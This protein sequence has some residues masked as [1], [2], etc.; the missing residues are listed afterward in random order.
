MEIEFT[1]K[2]IVYAYVTLGKSTYD[3]AKILKTYPNKVARVLEKA[4]IPLRTRAEAQKQALKSGRHEHPTRGRKRTE[5][6]KIKISES[7]AKNWENLSSEEKERRSKVAKE[8][9]EN[10][11]D[12]DRERIQKAAG[13]AIRES[14]E[15]GSKLERFLLIELGRRS[16]KVVFHKEAVVE[17]EK[18]QLDLFLS[19]MNPPV[20]IEIDGPAHFFPIW[21][22]ES[23]QKHISA[24]QQKNGLL[25][26]SGYIVLR[27]KHLT[28]NLSE[29][30]KRRALTDIL[31][32]LESISLKTPDEDKRLIE[33]EVK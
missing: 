30:Q 11:E 7:V 25:L 32:V 5:R 1:E 2:Y 24:D 6:E 17:N 16:Y 14:A 10:L 29:I 13:E 8:N 27:V 21:G 33:I 28:K 18:L 23:L 26:Q 31:N 3:I 22:E 4:G 12:K 19:E 9:W 20:V 15:I